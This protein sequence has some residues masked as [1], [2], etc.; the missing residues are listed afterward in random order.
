MRGI[1]F[2]G[3]HKKKIIKEII[4]VLNSKVKES[5]GCPFFLDDD[6]EYSLIFS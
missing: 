4:F 1:G 6:F 3:D 2:H 5:I